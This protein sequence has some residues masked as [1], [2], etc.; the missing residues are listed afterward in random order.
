MRK[1]QDMSRVTDVLR[2][3]S[4][5]TCPVDAD[6]C[7]TIMRESLHIQVLFTW[8]FQCTDLSSSTFLRRRN[9]VSNTTLQRCPSLKKEAKG[10]GGTVTQLCF[11]MYPKNLVKEVSKPSF[12][13]K[14]SMSTH[15][16][17]HLVVESLAVSHTCSRYQSCHLIG[18]VFYCRVA[19]HLRPLIS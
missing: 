16:V 7:S 15:S 4:R 8:F 5:C 6:M 17:L 12:R 18:R 1:T 14:H 19:Q 13:A 10:F 9:R 3:F 2:M 11:T